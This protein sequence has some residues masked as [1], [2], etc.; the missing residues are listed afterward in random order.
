M[1]PAPRFW[2]D[3]P[4]ILA[5]LLMPIAAAW[6]AAGRLQE[7]LSRPYCSPIPVICVGNLV[8]GGA[9]KTPVALALA[10]DLTA[11]GV[12]VHIVTRGYG[13]SLSGPVRIDPGRHR[14]PHRAVPRLQ[15][16]PSPTEE[17]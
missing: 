14:H 2:A 4:G 8:A 6:Q 15:G 11:R 13:G 17:E 3:P 16:T 12:A 1:R 5:D 10:A 7:R 9:G